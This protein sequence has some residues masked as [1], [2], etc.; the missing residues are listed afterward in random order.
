MAG[1]TYKD[2]NGARWVI[3]TGSGGMF[4][5]PDPTANPRYE[6]GALVP[7]T[8]IFRTRKEVEVDIERIASSFT[9][10]IKLVVTESAGG[11]GWIIL[12]VVL[13]LVLADSKR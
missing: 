1:D 6:E 7:D 11:S 8:A 9:Q 5:T 2:R 12:A 4:G 10:S 13:A 3:I